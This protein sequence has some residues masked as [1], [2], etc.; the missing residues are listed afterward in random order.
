MLSDLLCD[1]DTAR[2]AGVYPQTEQ[3]IWQTTKSNTTIITVEGIFSNSL[4]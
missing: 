1:T 4:H 3:S 2:A